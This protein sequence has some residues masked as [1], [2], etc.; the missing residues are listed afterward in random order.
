MNN[1][2]SGHN[3]S[4]YQL[5]T[6]E[7]QVL[8]NR[9]SFSIFRSIRWLY[10]QSLR[11]SLLISFLLSSWGWLLFDWLVSAFRARLNAFAASPIG[12]PE[13]ILQSEQFHALKVQRRNKSIVIN[14]SDR[15]PRVVILNRDDYIN[16]IM[17]VLEY[18]EKFIKIR[19]VDWF[20]K[21]QTIELNFQKRCFRLIF[22]KSL[23]RWL[24]CNSGYTG[25]LKAIR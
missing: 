19:S 16:K 22:M 13:F 9:F 24:C 2:K 4:N 25:Y 11:L 8:S 14:K 5:T 23:G 18:E 12:W 21:T 1:N 10:F 6:R 15:R 3:L 20:D 17:S 7:L